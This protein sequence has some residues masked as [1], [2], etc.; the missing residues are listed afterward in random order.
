MSAYLNSTPNSDCDKGHDISPEL[1][2]VKTP[3]EVVLQTLPLPDDFH[4]R[5]A[6]IYAL[7]IQRYNE[8][9]ASDAAGA[10][11]PEGGEHGNATVNP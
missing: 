9:A 10:T 1:P 4:N 8:R 11:E 2:Q 5:L 6:K 7:A 3:V